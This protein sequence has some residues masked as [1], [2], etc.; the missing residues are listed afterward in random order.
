MLCIDTEEGKQSK[1]GL[2]TNKNDFGFEFLPYFM[3]PENQYGNMEQE[4]NVD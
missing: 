4:R 1:G 2:G 3:E